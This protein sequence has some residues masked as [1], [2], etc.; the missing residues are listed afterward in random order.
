M[1]KYNYNDRVND[2]EKENT[3]NGLNKDQRLIEFDKKN[4]KGLSLDSLPL[5]NTKKYVSKQI[6]I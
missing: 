2:F 1:K 6:K 4:S 3:F 5:F